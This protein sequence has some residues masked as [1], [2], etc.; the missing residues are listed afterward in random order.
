MTIAKKAV[1]WGLFAAGGTL[2][3]FVYPALIVLFL[4]TSMGM[5]PANLQFDQFYAFASSWVGKLCLFVVLFLSLWH[6]AHRLRVVVHD[7]GIRQDK[8][9]AR[10]VY[11]VASLGTVL[12]A[13]YLLTI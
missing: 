5:V 7:F 8:L 6:A 2:T 13:F 9:V 10:A 12:T 1:V 11:T 3:S 4:L